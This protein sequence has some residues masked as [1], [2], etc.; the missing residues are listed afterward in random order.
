MKIKKLYTVNQYAT[1][2]A[3]TPQTVRVWADAGKIEVERTLGGHRRIV[4]W[5]DEESVTVC[6]CRVSSYKQKEDLARQ[7][8]FMRELYP[9]A[10]IIKDI[11]SGLNFKRKGLKALLDRAMRGDKLEVVVAHRDRLG[12]F[13]FDLLRWIIQRPAGTIVVLD[14]TEH[15]PEQELTRDLLAILH[16]FSCRLHGLR[17][18]KN[19]VDQALSNPKPEADI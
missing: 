7:V 9:N 5:I 2:K 16:V 10:E 6:Y 19:K 14:G 1:E 15:S 18:Y 12:R 11:G 3:I 17:S 4:E 8:A 13:G